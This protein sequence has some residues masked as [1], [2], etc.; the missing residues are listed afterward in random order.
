MK[1]SVR[2]EDVK[3]LDK[4]E[5][6]KKAK[7]LLEKAPYTTLTTTQYCNVP[8]YII[9]SL[10]M[11]NSQWPGPFETILLQTMKMSLQFSLLGPSVLRLGMDSL[12]LPEIT[13]WDKF[14][15]NFKLV[16]KHF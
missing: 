2:P 7:K 3:D 14:N 9:A 11:Y 6:A 1:V 12:S 8:D 16:K 4:T 5:P 15:T 10:E 13:V